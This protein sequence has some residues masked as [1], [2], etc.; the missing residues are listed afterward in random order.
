MVAE[1]AV[2]PAAGTSSST[3]ASVMNFVIAQLVMSTSVIDGLVK[4]MSDPSVDTDEVVKDGFAAVRE[5]ST[6]IGMRIE[7]EYVR[8][9]KIVEDKSCSGAVYVNRGT[10]SVMELLC[11]HYQG[12]QDVW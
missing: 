2:G 1:A 6:A 10:K 3:Q 11:I 8:T 5:G 9:T 7:G 4:K 12:I